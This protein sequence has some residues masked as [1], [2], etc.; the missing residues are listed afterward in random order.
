MNRANFL[1]FS[2]ASVAALFAPKRTEATP[3]TALVL[4]TFTKGQSAP[5]IEVKRNGGYVPL[6][7]ALHPD[8]PHGGALSEVTPEQREA[9]NQV[10]ECTLWVRDHPGTRT[11]SLYWDGP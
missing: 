1:S 8:N 9:I 4:E 11:A 5:V 10:M 7:S 6:T 2:L 3:K